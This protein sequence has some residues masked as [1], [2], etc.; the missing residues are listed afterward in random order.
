M[1]TASEARAA[2]ANLHDRE[3]RG[4]RLKITQPS[5]IGAWGRR[6]GES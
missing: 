4:Q 5:G 2:V 3:F 6:R 1:G